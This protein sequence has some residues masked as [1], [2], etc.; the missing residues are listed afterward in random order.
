MATGNIVRNTRNGIRFSMTQ[1]ADKVLIANNR[2]SAATEASIIGYDHA[3]PVT[4]DLAL[5]HAE[6]PAGV[7]ISNNL[8]S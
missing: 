4:G 3:D 8:V 5:P 7:V 1:G 2:I 6:I